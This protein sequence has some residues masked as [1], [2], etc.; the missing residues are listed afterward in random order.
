MDECAY[1]GTSTGCHR[2]AYDSVVP[3]CNMNSEHVAHAECF[4]QALRGARG[5][6]RV[7]S[8]PIC[9]DQFIH[10]LYTMIRAELDPFQM[11]DTVIPVTLKNSKSIP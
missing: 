6:E 10:Q 8:C 11:F 4:R 1:H 5:D 2:K 3:I 7:L 9:G